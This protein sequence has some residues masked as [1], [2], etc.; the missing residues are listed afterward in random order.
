MAYPTKRQ[1]FDIGAAFCD[2][3]ETQY[4]IINSVIHQWIWKSTMDI[5]LSRQKLFLRQGLNHE[6][7]AP[8]ELTI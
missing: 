6:A 1:A 2:A 4:I 5:T 3:R 8:L 7:L